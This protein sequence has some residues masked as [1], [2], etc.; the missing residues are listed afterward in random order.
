[1]AVVRDRIIRWLGHDLEPAMM[2]TFD[3]FEFAVLAELGLGAFARSNHG[4][5]LA[6]NAK[7]VKSLKFGGDGTMAPKRPESP[8]SANLPPAVCVKI[9]ITQ[10]PASDYLINLPARTGAAATVDSA[11]WSRSLCAA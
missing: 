4:Q 5:M 8:A 11:A 2:A 6:W 9:G 10:T 3:G 7:I 1:M